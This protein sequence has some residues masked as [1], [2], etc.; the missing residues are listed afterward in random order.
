MLLETA[1][2][3]ISAVLT[4]VLIDKLNLYRDQNLSEQVLRQKLREGY[5][6][7]HGAD[8]VFYFSE[9]AKRVLLEETPLHTIRQLSAA[10]EAIF[11]E[12]Q[13]SASEQDL[14]DAYVELDHWAVFGAFENERLVCAAS[15]YPWEGQKI[16]DLGV[17]TLP[18]FR[19]KGYASKVVRAISCYAC[20][21]GYEPQYRCQ[22]DNH[23][24]IA[25]A[26]KAGLTQLGKWE[27]IS[28]D[29]AE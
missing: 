20:N 8:Y 9:T 1:D 15:M 7:L 11:A 3:Q 4:P 18:P 28:P 22:I 25:L 6:E 24:S 12:F 17:L 23:A 27:V 21:L 29:S 16:A 2:G 5:V 14:G 10:D 26:K 13:S 19:G